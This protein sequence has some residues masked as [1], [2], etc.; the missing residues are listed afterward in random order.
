MENNNLKLIFVHNVGQSSKNY[1]IY[2]FIFSNDPTN[3]NYI[4]LNWDKNPA[5]NNAEIPTEEY[6]DAIY[7]V[8]ISEFELEC[9]SD[10]YDREYM[11]G[12]HTI[13]ALAYEKEREDDISSYDK[14]F[15]DDVDDDLP[16]LVFHYGMDFNEINELFYS[17]GISMEKL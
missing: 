15:G 7:S 6:Y 11:H 2:E 8:K 5:A 13:H 1:S 9:L 3:I 10:A 12:Y 4:D 14:M 16:L 17:R